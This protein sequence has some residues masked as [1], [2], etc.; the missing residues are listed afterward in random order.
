VPEEPQAGQTYVQ[1]VAVLGKPEAD[2]L[3]EILSKKGFHTLVAAGPNDKTF[4]VLVGPA[5]DTEVGKLKGDL[6]QLGFK[7]AFPKKY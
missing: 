3:A 2:V 1:A 4:R 7:G 5:K 6:E